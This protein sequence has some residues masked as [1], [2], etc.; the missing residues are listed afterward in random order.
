M[1]RSALR[2]IVGAIAAALLWYFLTP[3]YNSVLAIAAQPL[4]RIDPRL[5]H[6]ELRGFGE[7]IH[8]RGDD[9]HP[10]MPRALI[11]AAQL[12][13]NFVLFGGLFATNRNVLRDR[14]F[15]RL[16]IAL[17]ILVATHVLAVAVAVE[18][19][20]A[21]RVGA[22]S[23]A[24]YGPALQDF[25]AAFEYAYRLAGMFGI[26]FALWWFS[27]PSISQRSHARSAA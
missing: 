22:W 27:D 14:G 24:R 6:V 15:R 20:Y 13:Y 21:T 3:A 25:W 16:A 17:L 11:P 19:T 4:V 8:G 1:L 12:T 18:A 7:R 2:F 9:E 5:R 23:E 10:E 26:A